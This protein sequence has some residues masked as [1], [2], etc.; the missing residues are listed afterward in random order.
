MIKSTKCVDILIS[1]ATTK[2]A[3][4]TLK[5]PIKWLSMWLYDFLKRS[6]LMCIQKEK[7]CLQ[8]LI[9]I[10]IKIKMNFNRHKQC[11][12]KLKKDIKN[13]RI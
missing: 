5:L 11:R 1:S 8:V 6:P 9:E 3:A 10:E 7:E 4:V 12:M 13:I 2:T